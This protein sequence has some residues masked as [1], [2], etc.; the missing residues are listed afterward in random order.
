MLAIFHCFLYR[1]ILSRVRCT[2]IL[3]TILSHAV[4]LPLALQLILQLI[5]QQLQPREVV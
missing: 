5:A 3:Y 1:E 2:P 4:S